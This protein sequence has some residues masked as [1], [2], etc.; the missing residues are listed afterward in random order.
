V[1]TIA[2]LSRRTKN[3][4][5]DLAK[6]GLIKN[7]GD[8]RPRPIRENGPDPNKKNQVK[9]VL[10]PLKLHLNDSG[11]SPG[12]VQKCLLSTKLL[13]VFNQIFYHII[14]TGTC[15]FTIDITCC[16]LHIAPGL[17]GHDFKA[18]SCSIFVL[19]FMP[20]CL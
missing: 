18:F 1:Q 5:I 6:L 11:F 15:I 4:E 9:F 8:D 19:F 7:K 2:K 14:N 16:L 13:L 3:T 20:I 10:N 17:K 12:L